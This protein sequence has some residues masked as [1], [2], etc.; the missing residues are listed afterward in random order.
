MVGSEPFPKTVITVFHGGVPSDCLVEG[1][2][3]KVL[4]D[5]HQGRN[6]V[7]EGSA[8]PH[9]PPGFADCIVPTKILPAE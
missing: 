2:L 4:R 7:V 9:V 8:C 6:V 5:G 1:P 3:E